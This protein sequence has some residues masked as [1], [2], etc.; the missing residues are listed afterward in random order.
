[1][2]GLTNKLIDAG[3]S[4]LAGNTG[5]AQH[6]CRTLMESATYRAVREQ[7]LRRLP[8]GEEPLDMRYA[9]VERTLEILTAEFAAR[10]VAP[11]RV[12]QACAE[13]LELYKKVRPREGAAGKADSNG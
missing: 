10:G 11:E 4:I 13:M 8:T 9:M 6:E 5:L 1:M 3:T 12:A 2:A 7:G